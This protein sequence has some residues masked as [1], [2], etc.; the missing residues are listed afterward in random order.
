MKVDQATVMNNWKA[1]KD[2][3]P[4]PRHLV[5]VLTMHEKIKL[6]YWVPREDLQPGRMWSINGHCGGIGTSWEVK[7]PTH[8]HSLDEIAHESYLNV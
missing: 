7:P 8:W 4:P 2:E 1:V 5:L 3:L 6:G